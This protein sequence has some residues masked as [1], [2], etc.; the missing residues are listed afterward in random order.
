MIL[1]DVA[2][3]F[4]ARRLLDMP[5]WRLKKEIPGVI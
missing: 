4:F 1:A 5:S 2:R 3:G